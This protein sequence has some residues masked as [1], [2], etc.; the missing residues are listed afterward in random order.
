MI[1]KKRKSITIEGTK[2]KLEEIT[3]ERLKKTKLGQKIE[4]E[5]PELKMLVDQ[6][7]ITL[8]DSMKIKE[9]ETGEGKDYKKEDKGKYKITE[10][11]VW[12]LRKIKKG[13]EEEWV[14]YEEIHKDGFKNKAV[15]V[16]GLYEDG[17]RFAMK[18]GKFTITEIN[19]KVICTPYLEEG[20]TTW[21]G[22]FV[23]FS[24]F[25]AFVALVV[26]G[27]KWLYIKED[28]LEEDELEEDEEL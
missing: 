19:G 25:A 12:I 1:K 7:E 26:G 14:P 28:E 10:V 15:I 20:E 21:W 9:S 2:V 3:E 18:S 8:E 23:W 4:F 17:G 13:K 11:N 5:K 6:K 24:L 27:G 22:T 16:N